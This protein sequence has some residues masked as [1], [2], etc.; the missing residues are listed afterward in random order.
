MAIK[1]KFEIYG[2]KLL[3]NNEKLNIVIRA[4]FNATEQTQ[5]SIPYDVINNHYDF[6]NSEAV[7]SEIIDA[8]EDLSS[9]VLHIGVQRPMKIKY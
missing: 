8:S 2:A 4:Y 9:I 7:D 1:D 6:D 3:H 5:T